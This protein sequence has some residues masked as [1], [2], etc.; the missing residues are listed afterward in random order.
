MLLIN[1]SRFT[2]ILFIC[3]VFSVFT[4]MVTYASL[5]DGQPEIIMPPLPV[6]KDIN[7]ELS[8]TQQCCYCIDLIPNIPGS[9]TAYVNKIKTSDFKYMR[10]L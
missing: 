4:T 3:C 7:T 8:Y 1:S 2:E 5:C 9:Q 6:S 10:Y